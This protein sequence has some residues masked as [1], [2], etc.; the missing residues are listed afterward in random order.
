MRQSP[1][2]TPAPSTRLRNGLIAAASFLLASLSASGLAHAA[3]TDLK[4]S[5]YQVAD[6]Q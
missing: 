1:T 3:F 2:V 4:F 6:S 5:R